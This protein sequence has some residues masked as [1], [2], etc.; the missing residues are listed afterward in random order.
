MAG[1]D[2][3]L[4]SLFSPDQ[5]SSSTP[6]PAGGYNPDFDNNG[7]SVNALDRLKA[8][9]GGSLP[10]DMSNPR[11]G[12]LDQLTGYL[13]GPSGASMMQDDANKSLGISD[14]VPRPPAP[15]PY[16]P[17][18]SP[19]MPPMPP[20]GGNAAVTPP[21]PQQPPDALA[22]SAKSNQQPD[23]SIPLPQPRP[24]VESIL[25]GQTPMNGAPPAAPTAP[26]TPPAP[27][28]GLL[29]RLAGVTPS[30]AQPANANGTAA[31][32]TGLMGKLAGM[33]ASGEKRLRSSLAGGM[34][35]ANPA[36]A[37]G[38]IMNGLSG[39]LKG[40]LSSDKDDQDQAIKLAGINA[41]SSLGAATLAD[42][43]KR[44][45]ALTKLYDART[46][47]TVNGKP[48]NSWNKP[49]SERWKDAQNLII[50]KQKQLQNAINPLAPKAAQDQQRQAAQQELQDF[51]NST[52][53]AYGFDKD[54]NDI[55]G[56][57]SSG[58]PATPSTAK[59]VGDK[60]GED[61]GLYEPKGKMVGSG[62]TDD[63][64]TPQ[65]SDD[66]DKIKP[67]E[68]FVNPADGKTMRKRGQQQGALDTPDD[69]S[70]TA[71]S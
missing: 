8:Q 41:K 36:F 34:S 45:D 12:A 37:G 28:A 4:A 66:F 65:T 42:R 63:P 35:G 60:E 20:Q 40:G 57:N 51:K 18:M 67:G 23:P 22:L 5:G 16:N 49:P 59:T 27:N 44:T 10:T 47:A 46:T 25:A 32:A 54:G 1:L 26:G 19:D 33:D 43:Q 31:P 6:L 3:F 13:S 39:G 68:I 11:N 71:E 52:Y 50:N 58:K 14:A 21:S 62:S 38:A 48:N 15:T 30:G 55:S 56:A 61:S 24:D 69:Q 2:D 70:D 9:F 7:Q 29:A 53:H 17:A 64:Y